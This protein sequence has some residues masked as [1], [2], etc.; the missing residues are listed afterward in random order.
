MSDFTDD[1]DVDSP[2]P[3]ESEEEVAEQQP[4]DSQFLK[5]TNDFAVFSA[6]CAFLCDAFSAIA[7]EQEDIDDY[8]SYGLKRY[9]WQLKAQ[10]IALD[11]RIHQLQRRMREEAC[12]EPEQPDS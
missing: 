9:G 1:P 12:S 8:T 6:D 2:S 7:D 3:E 5:L 10:V 11:Q 4:I